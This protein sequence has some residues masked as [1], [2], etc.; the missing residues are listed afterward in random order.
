MRIV[1]L[2]AI[3]RNPPLLCKA[4]EFRRDASFILAGMRTGGPFALRPHLGQEPANLVEIGRGSDRP[5]DGPQQRRIGV[6]TNQGH[7][8]H[9]LGTE[10]RLEAVLDG[11]NRG[12]VRN[13]VSGASE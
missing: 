9:S 3:E 1:P 11:Q 8:R 2:T 7:Q 6:L 4:V 10:L 13:F 12:P 5:V